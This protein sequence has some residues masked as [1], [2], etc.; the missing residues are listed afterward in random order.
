MNVDLLSD[1]QCSDQFRYQCRSMLVSYPPRLLSVAGA[2]GL[3]IDSEIESM[4]LAAS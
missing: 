4:R 1:A 3:L 2:H